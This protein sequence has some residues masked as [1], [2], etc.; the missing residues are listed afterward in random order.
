MTCIFSG[1]SCVLVDQAAQD[2]FSQDLSGAEAFR[3][4]AVS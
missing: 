4:D 2:G 1:G 3:G